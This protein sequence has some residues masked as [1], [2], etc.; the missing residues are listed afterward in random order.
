MRQFSMLHCNNCGVDDQR[1]YKTTNIGSYSS[2]FNNANCLLSTR[3]KGAFLKI[4]GNDDDD[5][6][7]GNFG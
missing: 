3:I 2:Q 7:G 6:R 1:H 4:F 5:F